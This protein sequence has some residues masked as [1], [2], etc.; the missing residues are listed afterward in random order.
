L[1][2]AEQT[3]PNGNI[4]VAYTY[5][6][7]FVGY[8]F[9]G[10]C[11]KLVR[12]AGL[13]NVLVTNGYVNREPLEELLPYINAM[14]IDLKCFSEGGYKK[15]GGSLEPVKETIARAYGRCHLEITTLIIPGEN[16]TDEEIS[17]LARWLAALGTEIP[18]HLSRFFPQYR[19]TEDRMATPRESI[20]RLRE[21]AKQHLQ[22][23]FAGNMG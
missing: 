19:Y 4:G 9:I 20:L 22:Y 3:K 2:L 13:C 1:A 11:A 7:P 10:D 23:V 5:N 15:L 12:E 18:L 17:E 21:I 16:D 8:E 14:N 6:E